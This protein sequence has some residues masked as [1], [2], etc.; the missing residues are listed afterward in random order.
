[1]RIQ[2]DPAARGAGDGAGGV[3]LAGGRS[4]R[5]GTSKAA[6]DWHGSTLLYRAAAMLARSVDGPI[7]VVRAPGQPLPALPPGV[8]VVEDGIEGLGPLRGIADG[9]AAIHDR[10]AS[11]FV[12]STDAPLLCPSFVRAVLRRLTPEVDVA[13][14]V[15]HGYA[16]PLAAV[17]RTAV[18]A[19]ARQLSETGRNCPTALLDELRVRR[20]DEAALLADPLL[21]SADPELTSL[22]N[23]N[24]PADYRDALSRP[25]PVV[26]VSYGASMHT[27]QAST[28]GA[29]ARA[30]GAPVMSHTPLSLNGGDAAT[31]S[32][33]FPLVE[34]D[35]LVFVSANAVWAPHTA[36]TYS[37]DPTPELCRGP[38]RV[39]FARLGNAP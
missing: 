32:S 17:Y 11:A 35:S 4:S 20:L 31:H 9:L 15:A 39:Q 24:S 19:R 28:L 7:V 5:M 21:S 10:T 12:C 26:T 14:P 30:I 16:Q 38:L 3:V 18:A 2:D 36:R 8:E 1:M 29:V 37:A 25:E 27:M 23:I 34:G 22:T 6:L 33:Q 13:V